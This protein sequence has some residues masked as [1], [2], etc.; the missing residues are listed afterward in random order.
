MGTGVVARDV[1]AV[2]LPLLL[3]LL[4]L[5]L[6]ELRLLFRG[7]VK[8]RALW[9]SDESRLLLLLLVGGSRRARV[10]W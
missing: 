2:R 10:C 1:C 4:L 6:L 3:L 5:L 8:A 7:S 9:C